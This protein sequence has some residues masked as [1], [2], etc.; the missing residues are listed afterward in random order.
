MAAQLLDDDPAAELALELAHEFSTELE[1]LSKL[2]VRIYKAQ[3]C[4]I[5]RI[6]RLA[7]LEIDG[8]VSSVAIL[9]RQNS[10]LTKSLEQYLRLVGAEYLEASIGE[11]VRRLCAEGIDLEID[12]SRMKPGY[13]EKELNANIQGLKEWTMAVWTSIYDARE[14][15]PR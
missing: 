6:L 10:I 15:C 12:P 14:K 5:P 3:G 11:P 4:L 13:K 2:L 7:E 1:D 8:D 9:F